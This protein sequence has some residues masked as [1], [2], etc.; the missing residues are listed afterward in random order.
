MVEYVTID[1]NSSSS[2]TSVYHYHQQQSTATNGR[3]CEQAERG[4][5]E[6]EEGGG[7]GEGEQE[8]SQV[9]STNQPNKQTNR[10]LREGEQERS[11][12]GALT[13]SALSLGQGG[14]SSLSLSLLLLSYEDH[15][16]A[17]IVK[18]PPCWRYA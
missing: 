1:I 6:T 12:V 13:L 17:V 2:S 10:G 3:C 7:L 5:G 8:C 9:I 16:A 15:R 18:S 14:L 4:G 11:Q